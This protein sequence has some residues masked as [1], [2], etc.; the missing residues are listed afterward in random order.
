MVTQKKVETISSPVHCL[1]ICVGKSGTGTGCALSILTGLS[2]VIFLPVLHFHSF[3]RNLL[4]LHNRPISGRSIEGRPLDPPASN[5]GC[6]YEA[7][8]TSVEK[9][10]R[11]S[12]LLILNIRLL[13]LTI[14]DHFPCR[15]HY[16]LGVVVSRAVES[17]SWIRSLKEFY[18]ESESESAKMYRLRPESKILT[19]YSNSRALIATVTI[20]LT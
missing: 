16:L 18:V 1:N 17:E 6:Q 2:S 4:R 13:R 12:R 5:P 19:R 9:P 7:E 10:T 20:R 3:H 15:N 11:L 8:R 14:Y